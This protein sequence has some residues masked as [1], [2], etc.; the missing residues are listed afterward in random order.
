M[1][2]GLESGL[3]ELRRGSDSRRINHLILLTDGQ[4]YG[5]EQACLD[6]ASQAA[7]EGIGISAM[8]IGADWND[9]FLDQVAS[10]TGNT[11]RYIA[12]PQDIQK[13]LTEKF[14]ALANVVAPPT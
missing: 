12:R 2:R 7:R 10:R 8:G 4:T 14:N 13:L 9:S 5:D 1:L 3:N 6:L 11:S